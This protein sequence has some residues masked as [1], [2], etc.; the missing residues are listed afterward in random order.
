MRK[1]INADLL[2]EKL[3][4]LEEL[5]NVRKEKAGD[6]KQKLIFD[7]YKATLR[8]VRSTIEKLR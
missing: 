2:H 1:T 8:E 7:C 3:N 5:Y 6:E 4:E